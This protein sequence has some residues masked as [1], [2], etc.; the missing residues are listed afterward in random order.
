MHKH[1]QG[2]IFDT[3]ASFCLALWSR[4]QCPVNYTKDQDLNGP[5]ITLHAT[6][7]Q[8]QQ[9][10]SFL[11]ICPHDNYSLVLQHQMVNQ[12]TNCYNT[13]KGKDM[14]CFSLLFYLPCYD[15]HLATCKQ[16]TMENGHYFCH[17]LTKITS[18]VR[19]VLRLSL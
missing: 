8:L 3:S 18:F 4:T 14:W 12:L 9:S 17:I 19:K 16:V 1:T 10:F 11:S 15:K 6:A 5:L 13:Q 7:Q 2:D